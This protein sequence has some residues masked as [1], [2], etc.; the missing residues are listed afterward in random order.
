[1]CPAKRCSVGVFGK[2]GDDAVEVNELPGHAQVDQ[3]LTVCFEEG[4]YGVRPTIV[5]YAIGVVAVLTGVNVGR[6]DERNVVLA[7][8]LL[9]RPAEVAPGDGVYD[10]DVRR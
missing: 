9:G 1:V 7:R 5:R 10:V 3:Q 2:Q 4:E 8:H 6:H